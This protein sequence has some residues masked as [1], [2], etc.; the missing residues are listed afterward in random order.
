[1]TKHLSTLVLLL[2]SIILIGCTK[3]VPAGYVGLRQKPSG[4]QA[5]S[6][7]P[8][9]H[10]CWGPCAMLL[11]E[12]SES[13]YK[14]QMS[15]LCQDDLNMKFDLKIRARLAVTDGE[16]LRTV[17]NNQGSKMEKGILAFDVLYRTYVRPQARAIARTHVSKLA[18]TDIRDHRARIQDAITKDLRESLKGTPVE[19]TMVVTSNLDYPD[20]ITTAMEKKRQRE[21][22]I[23]EEEAKQKMEVLRAD[24]RRKVAE[25]MRVTRAA[26]AEAEAAYNVI[27]SKSLTPQYLRMRRIEADLLL[28]ERVGPGDKVIVTNGGPPPALMLSK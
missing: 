18:N 7:Q 22:E 15:V 3:T 19:I 9:R 17:L 2:G 20:V 26:E 21:I 12:T 4:I 8:G 11:V 25:I 23:Q 14:E 27:L 13:T 24:N 1:M 28:Y 16:G 10:S 5:E 6:L